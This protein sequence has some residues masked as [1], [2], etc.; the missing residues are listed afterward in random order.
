MLVDGGLYDN[1][2]AHKFNSHDDYFNVSYAIVSDAG[3][4]VMSSKWD[5]NPLFTLLSSANIMMRRIKNFQRQHNSY[6]PSDKKKVI[7]AYNDLMWNDYDSMVDRFVDNIKRKYIPENVL[8]FH[9]I[10]NEQVEDMRAGSDKAQKEIQSRIEANINWHE[11][12]SLKPKKHDIGKK[13]GTNLVGL[14]DKKIDA[15]IEHAEWLTEVQVRLH[16]PFL[17]TEK[18]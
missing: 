6:V 12:L 18:T 17:I 14:S 3:N 5:I 7:F 9:G 2:G 8:R 11:L 4:T 16:L 10:T 13:V 1:Q 15:L